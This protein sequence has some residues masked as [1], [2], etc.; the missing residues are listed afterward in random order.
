MAFIVKFEILKLDTY[1]H[2]TVSQQYHKE[3]R[4][5]L[6]FHPQYVDVTSSICNMI[7]PSKY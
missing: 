2:D 1:R 3:P 7:P 4:F 5:C 6:L